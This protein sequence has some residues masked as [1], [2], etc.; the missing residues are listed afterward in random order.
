MDDLYSVEM[1]VKVHKLSRVN[2]DARTAVR[3]VIAAP[4]ALEFQADMS[5]YLVLFLH[6]L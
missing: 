3:M 1:P 5:Y 4:V 2:G 6:T